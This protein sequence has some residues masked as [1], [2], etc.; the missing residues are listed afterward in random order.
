M[1]TPEGV[2]ALFGKSLKQDVTMM[3]VIVQ[4]LYDQRAW[5]LWFFAFCVLLG[6]RIAYKMGVR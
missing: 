3:R 4:T 1:S 5:S 2:A 6:W